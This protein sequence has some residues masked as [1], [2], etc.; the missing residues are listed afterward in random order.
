MSV[1][2]YAVRWDGPD[3]AREYYHLYRQI[4]ERKWDGLELVDSGEG[5]CEGAGPAGRVALELDGS[6]VRSVEG[7]PL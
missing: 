6:T 3:A 2:L 4:C 5:Q 1:L 7:L